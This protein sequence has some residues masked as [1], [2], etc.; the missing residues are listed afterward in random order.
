MPSGK[1][2]ILTAHTAFITW[3]NKIKFKLFVI[4]NQ[5]ECT[6][7]REVFPSYGRRKRRAVSDEEAKSLVNATNADLTLSQ[8]ILVLDFNEELPTNM[9]KYSMPNNDP[10]DNSI[11]GGYGSD[12]KY[13]SGGYGRSPYGSDFNN[14]QFNNPGGFGP[15]HRPTYSEEYGPSVSCPTRNSVLVLSVVCAMLLLL[16]VASAVCFMAKS[17]PWRGSSMGHH[18]HIMQ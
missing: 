2:N 3:L 11:G 9:P 15:H 8:E 17:R 16:Y 14:N 1:F 6:H 18:K 5:A 7:N 13:G 10:M 12:S 4:L